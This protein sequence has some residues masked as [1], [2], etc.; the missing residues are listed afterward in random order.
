MIS[1]INS[2]TV[3]SA[4]I[5]VSAFVM[6]GISSG[7]GLLSRMAKK[8]ASLSFVVLELILSAWTSLLNADQGMCSQFDSSTS[9]AIRTLELASALRDR[10]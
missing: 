10:R 2:W 8:S 1:W 3:G 4:S 6:G 9:R 5:K 7:C